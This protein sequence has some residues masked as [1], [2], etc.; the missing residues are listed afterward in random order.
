[1]AGIAVIA[2]GLSPPAGAAAASPAQ[3]ASIQITGWGNVT[4]GQ[5]TIRC[6]AATCL[7]RGYAVPGSRLVLVE[8]PYKGWRFA[9]WRGACA[10]PRPK[11]AIRSARRVRVN[12][13][14]VPVAA[15]LTPEHPIPL[16]TTASIGGGYRVRVNS[17]LPDAQLSPAAPAGEAYLAANVTLSYTGH[18]EGD[19]GSLVWE[20]VTNYG[21]GSYGPSHSVTAF[22]DPPYPAPQPPLDYL[23]PL[24]QGRSTT[25]YVCWTVEEGEEAGIDE[26]LLAVFPHTTWFA[27]R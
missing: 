20:T 18:G 2:V 1:L 19:V 26:L 9:G 10:G 5:R 17:V 27:L 14:F 11:C 12:A 24:L 23:H 15:G 8:R 25:G 3:H 7:A 4:L 13:R 16:G 22:G 21:G 6:T